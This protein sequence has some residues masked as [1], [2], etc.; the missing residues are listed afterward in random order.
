MHAR[1]VESYSKPA[2]VGEAA[3]WC[4]GGCTENTDDAIPRGG[5][6]SEGGDW[7]WDC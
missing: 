1:N 2:L 5:G 4:G 6:R 3:G 7:H